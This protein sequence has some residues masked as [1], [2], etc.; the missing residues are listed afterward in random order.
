MS[1]KIYELTMRCHRYLGRIILD[2]IHYFQIGDNTI[3]EIVDSII[4]NYVNG[5]NLV[6]YKLPS[7]VLDKLYNQLED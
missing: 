6:D 5:K 7:H 3:D 2:N 4:E 1:D